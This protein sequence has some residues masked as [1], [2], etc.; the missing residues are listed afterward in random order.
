VE[1]ARK[2]VVR[3]KSTA[4][5]DTSKGPVVGKAWGLRKGVSV[6]SANAKMNV[7]TNHKK[8][9]KKKHRQTPPHHTPRVYPSLEATLRDQG[10]W[11]RGGSN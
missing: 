3:L 10:T 8:R 1:K 2:H 9:K 6:G 11:E 5:V 4:H 7:S